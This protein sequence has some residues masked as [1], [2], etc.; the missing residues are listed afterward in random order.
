M[1][2]LKNNIFRIKTPIVHGTLKF[3]LKDIHKN[4]VHKEITFTRAKTKYIELNLNNLEDHFHYEY[5]FEKKEDESW[6]IL[7]NNRRIVPVFQD[8]E[9]NIN[10]SYNNFSNS[11]QLYV[12]FS[13]S[14][15]TN[16]FN[17][18]K[19]FSEVE[20]NKLFIVDENIFNMD[21]TSA[22][23]LG[24]NKGKDYENKIHSLIEKYRVKNNI[25]KKD[26]V[27]VGSSKGGFAA[28]YYQFKY[29]YGKS[30]VGSPTIFLG[31]I[32][33]H[34][35]KGRKLIT[36]LTGGYSSENID[37]LNGV[38]LREVDNQ[39]NSP[40]IFYHVGEREIRYT[41]HAV[42]FIDVLKTYDLSLSDLDLGNYDNH[43]DVA[44]F[45]PKYILK[46]IEKI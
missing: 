14:N 3:I 28:L 37:W 4:I 16:T 8:Y 22:Y 2:R 7:S 46:V 9:H 13:S 36:Y 26:V 32:H 40:E 41:K 38:I 20:Q 35:E 11:N 33:R 12:I 21:S 25:H 45:F 23:Y 43:S 17:Y 30:I 39:H 24:K 34:T 1:I 19:T 6:Q 15:E 44:N 27:L 29:K 10:F 18:L 5:R 31:D 42:P